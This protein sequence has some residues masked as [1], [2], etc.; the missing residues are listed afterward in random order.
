MRINDKVISRL[1]LKSEQLF[2]DRLDIDKVVNK[3]KVRII[4]RDKSNSSK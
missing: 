1:H 2:I 3:S 4:K